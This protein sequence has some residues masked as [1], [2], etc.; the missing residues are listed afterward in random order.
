MRFSCT[1]ENLNKI[2]RV[3]STISAKNINLPILRNL[4]ISAEEHGLKLLAT[5]LEI[6][7]R[8][9]I[10]GKVEETG[11]F[12]VPIKLLSDYIALVD[13]DKIDFDLKNNELK[14][15]ST[16]SETH[17]KGQGASEFPVVPEIEK[18]KTFLVSNQGLLRSINQVIFSVSSNDLRPEISGVLFKFNDGKLILTGTDSFRLAEKS[19]VLDENSAVASFIVP[20]KTVEE[21][22]KVLSVEEEIGDKNQVEIV[23]GNNQ[24]L[25][26][27]GNLELISR[28]IEGSYPNYE[29]IIPKNFITEVVVPR[30]QLLKIVKMSSLFSRSGM[31][32]VTLTFERDKIIISSN[33]ANVGA[34]NSSLP[35]EVKGNTNKIVLNHRYL[36]EGLQ[37]FDSKNIL[38]KTIDAANPMMMQSHEEIKE[39]EEGKNDYFYL[40]MP[41]RQ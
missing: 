32:D 35:A 28:L 11:E 22:S 23:L 34:Y 40:L 36:Q 37:A 29:Q 25:F 17:I 8:A 10:R 14:I 24:V 13:A 20:L 2:L 5:N 31:F 4:L 1:K 26:R 39:G 7:V 27:Y 16:N 18:N 15:S 9:F 41:I 21:L 30:E 6:A 12:T 33:D 38:I 3:V 19:L